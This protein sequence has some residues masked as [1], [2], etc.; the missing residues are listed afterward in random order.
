ML[1]RTTLAAACL[2]VGLSACGETAADT[3]A[4]GEDGME[5]MEPTDAATGSGAALAEAQR[6]AVIAHIAQD[7]EECTMPEGVERETEIVDLGDGVGAVIVTCAVGMPDVWSR[8]YVVQEGGGHHMAVPLIQY[9]IRGD[10]L[11]RGESTSPNLTW[12]PEDR[13]FHASHGGGGG[14]GGSTR[15]RWDGEEIVLVEQTVTEGCETLGANDPIPDPRV[16]WP[17]DPATPEPTSE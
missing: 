6:E 14:C 12:L 9:D 8:L 13:V 4:S 15:W 2:A 16:I 3:P 5:A 17:T 10:G 11:W 7:T 1:I